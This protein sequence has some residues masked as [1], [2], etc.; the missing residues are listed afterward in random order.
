MIKVVGNSS[1][2]KRANALLLLK[3]LRHN[4]LSRVELS[5]KSGLQAST[6]TYI[7]NRFLECGTVNEIAMAENA[8]SGSGRK[9]SVIGINKDKGWV[10]G[11]ELMSG[12][13]RIAILDALGNIV[14]IEELKYSASKIEKGRDEFI[15]FSS[16]ALSYALSILGDKEPLGAVI[17]VPGIVKEGN[18]VIE[19]CWTHGLYNEDFTAFLSSF[20]FP[21][22]LENDANCSVERFINSSEDENGT[23]IYLLS[24]LHKKESVPFN[25]PIIGLGYGFIIEGKLFRGSQSRSGEYRSSRALRRNG[26]NQVSINNE[27]L[28]SLE[29]DDNLKRDLVREVLSDA[30]SYISLFDPTYFYIGGFLSSPEYQE[31]AENILSNYLEVNQSYSKRIIF[32]T[33][34]A[35]AA[36]G[37]ASLALSKLYSV[38]HIGDKVSEKFQ[39]TGLLPDIS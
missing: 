23:I 31:I 35:D 24:R 21:V 1:F 28:L 37:A 27:E 29:S 36:I 14:R 4:P 6:V 15:A 7:I 13:A 10:I 30:L 33:D 20:S 17:A 16:E 18:T 38:P 26:P 32:S 34:Q 5:E 2:Q 11:I 19:E 25:I 3:L 12:L 8:N 39:F 22:L 9:R